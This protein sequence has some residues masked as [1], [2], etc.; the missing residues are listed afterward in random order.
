MVGNGATNWDVDVSPSFPETLY[1]FNMIPKHLIDF[2]NENG[3]VYYFND[4]REHSGPKTCDAV[5]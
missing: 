5:W 2:M 4:Y 1:Q 3:C